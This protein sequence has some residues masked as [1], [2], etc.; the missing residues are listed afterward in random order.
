MTVIVN[1]CT[2]AWALDTP[3][4]HREIA[5]PYTFVIEWPEGH[6]CHGLGEEIDVVAESYREAREHGW[7][8]TRAAFEPS[9]SD[10]RWVRT[11]GSG[12]WVTFS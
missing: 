3:E 6:P 8:I 5:K 4:T 2:C 12:G 9:A 7:A 10:L 1:T 11:G